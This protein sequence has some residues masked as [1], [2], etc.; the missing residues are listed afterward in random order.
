MQ[1]NPDKA[2]QLMGQS[3]QQRFQQIFGTQA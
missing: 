3:F 1:D 2:E